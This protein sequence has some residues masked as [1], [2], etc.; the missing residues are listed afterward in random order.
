MIDPRTLF[1]SEVCFEHDPMTGL[2]PEG[3]SFHLNV[4]TLFNLS[5][6]KVGCYNEKLQIFNMCYC[7]V[8]LILNLCAL[9][10]VC[11][12]GVNMRSLSVCVGVCVCERVCK[13]VCVCVSLCV[14]PS[15]CVC[16]PLCVCVCVCM[17][18][19]MHALVCP[20]Y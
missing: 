5:G 18:L 9:W 15:V 3:F 20:P 10:L 4:Y 7:T 14:C 1:V 11:V 2:Y 17:C 8:K 6:F 12:V 19:C 16:D 13:C